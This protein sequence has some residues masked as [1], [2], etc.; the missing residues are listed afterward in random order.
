[1]ELKEISQEIREILKQKRNELRISFQESKHIYYMMDE[2]G[3]I[4][5]NFPSVTKIVKKFHKPFDAQGIS[6]SMAKGDL[7]EQ[8]RLLAEWKLSGELS[9]NLGSRSHYELEKEL[10][11]RYDDY[12]DVR[13]PVFECNEEQIIKSNK[14]ISAGINFL[15]VM[16][17]RGAELLDTELIMGHPKEKYIG[18]CDNAWI[19]MNKEKN[20]FGFVLS[21]WKTNAPKNFKI[22]PYNNKLYE[23]F[24]EYPDNAL[25]QYYLQIPLYGRLLVK[26]LEGTKFEKNKFL[27]GVLILLK[28]DGTYEEFK[29]PQ[30]II[31]TILS[32]DLSPFLK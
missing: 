7:A 1:M 12:K 9:V 15:N 25:G 5:S 32:M 17:E 21:D 2:N 20:D 22:F 18:Q 30:Y 26:M 19:M 28:E 8:Q 31:S 29:V 10:V 16:K 14:M 13:Q 3:K 23:P 11:S 24:S 4:R 6:L 27:G